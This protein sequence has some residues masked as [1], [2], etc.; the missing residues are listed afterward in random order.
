MQPSEIPRIYTQPALPTQL[1][2]DKIRFSRS[3]TPTTPK[4]SPPISPKDDTSLGPFGILPEDMIIHI[5]SYLTH[6]HLYCL[7]RTCK[8]FKRLA[9]DNSLQLVIQKKH[10]QALK[11]FREGIPICIGFSSQSL[12]GSLEYRRAVFPNIINLQGEEFSRAYSNCD[13]MQKATIDENGYICA[14]AKPERVKN[15]RACVLAKDPLGT[16]L[17]KFFPHEASKEFKVISFWEAGRFRVKDLED[18]DDSS[19]SRSSPRI[20]GDGSP[21]SPKTRST[22]K[23][24]RLEYRG[25]DLNPM[26]RKV[27]ERALQELNKRPIETLIRTRGELS[28]IDGQDHF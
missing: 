7:T 1:P 9:N 13:F 18:I 4:T 28:F 17:I 2:V 5:L 6:H 11:I 10:A 26:Q 15:L 12:K 27:I 24:V 23:L 8:V 22:W 16:K 20:R 14:I 19:P 21:H 3:N 25:E